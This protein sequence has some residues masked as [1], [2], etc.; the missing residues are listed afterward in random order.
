MG[1]VP[2]KALQVDWGGQKKRNISLK[3]IYIYIV[4]STVLFNY[5]RYWACFNTKMQLVLKFS[6]PR[7]FLKQGF[8]SLVKPKGKFHKCLTA[9]NCRLN[10]YFTPFIAQPTMMKTMKI[11]FCQLTSIIW[12]VFLDGPERGKKIPGLLHQLS[13]HFEENGIIVHDNR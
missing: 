2:T 5:N 8:I 13:S 3:W 7:K 6:P 11:F 1:K 12:H 9:S 10:I 4:L